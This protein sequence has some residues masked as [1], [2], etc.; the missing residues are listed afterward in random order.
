M[1]IHNIHA[2]KYSTKLGSYFWQ[3]KAGGA[4]VLVSVRTESCCQFV[5]VNFI[6]LT[7]FLLLLS[8]ESVSQ[9]VGESTPGGQV[10]V[11]PRCVPSG[12]W[13]NEWVTPLIAPSKFKPVRRGR[14]SACQQRGRSR[15]NA[16]VLLHLKIRVKA[17]K[18]RAARRKSFEDGALALA[19][20][21]INHRNKMSVRRPVAIN[22]ILDAKWKVAAPIFQFRE[23]RPGVA[24]SRGCTEGSSSSYCEITLLPP[25]VTF[26]NAIYFN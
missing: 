18:G 4:S 7:N 14:Q 3:D 24:S 8:V 23:S 12:G 13:R 21:G 10:L 5:L 9:S 17:E 6:L 26:P 25:N 19:C 1:R 15:N 22:Y 11:R 20:V 16:N 2:F